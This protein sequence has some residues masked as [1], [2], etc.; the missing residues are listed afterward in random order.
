M[1]AWA[2]T[3]ILAVIVALIVRAEI[4]CGRRSKDFMN[5]VMPEIDALKKSAV[6]KYQAKYGRAPTEPLPVV[7]PPRRGLFRK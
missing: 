2:F 6:R 7:E 1:T 5:T 4:R 3:I